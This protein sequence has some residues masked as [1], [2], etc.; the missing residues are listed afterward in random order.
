MIVFPIH[1]SPFNRVAKTNWYAF[2]MTL[3]WPK[4]SAALTILPTV[5]SLN[6]SLPTGAKVASQ[7]TFLV[8]TTLAY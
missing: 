5:W 3:L 4:S 2:A 6:W 1:S 8:V 7:E